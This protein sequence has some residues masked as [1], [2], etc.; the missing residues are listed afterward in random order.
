MAA[1]PRHGGGQLGRKLARAEMQSV[2]V[3]A[4]CRR[5]A[6]GRRRRGEPGRAGGAEADGARP[7]RPVTPDAD[8]ER[9]RRRASASRLREQRAGRVRRRALGFQLPKFLSVRFG[10]G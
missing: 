10:N 5:R 4:A 3:A 9:P 2:G 8:E 1:G 7:R 6:G